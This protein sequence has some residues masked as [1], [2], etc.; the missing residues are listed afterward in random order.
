MRE[1][2]FLF[3]DTPGDAGDKQFGVIGLI[4]IDEKQG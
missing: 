1:S 4:R 2:S 3:F